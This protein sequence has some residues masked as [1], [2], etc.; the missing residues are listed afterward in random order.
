MCSKMYSLTKKHELLPWTYFL[1][2]NCIRCGNCCNKLDVQLTSKEAHYYSKH[3]GDVIEKIKDG[4]KLKRKSNGEC[5]FL[6]FENNIAKCKIYNDRP[7]ACRIYPFYVRKLKEYKD[8]SQEIL[9]N[10]EIRYR[11]RKYIVFVSNICLGLGRGPPISYAV[12]HA[13]RMKFKK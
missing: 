7:F 8:L 5:I 3:Y 13:I 12:K 10:A 11:K 1:R 2:W 9:K 4:Y 6:D